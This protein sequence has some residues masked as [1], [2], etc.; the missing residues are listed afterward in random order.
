MQGLWPARVL[1]L[2]RLNQAGQLFL[3]QTR[4]L[5]RESACS[6]IVKLLHPW[7]YL[8]VGGEHCNARFFG[9]EHV[10]WLAF[11]QIGQDSLD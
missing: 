3:V 7:F 10:A 4:L 9:E 6:L 11:R 1:F 2:E 8:F 5:I